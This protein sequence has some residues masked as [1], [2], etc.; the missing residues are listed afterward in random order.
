MS[1]IPGYVE[2]RSSTIMAAAAKACDCLE[3]EK[4]KVDTAHVEWLAKA[5]AFYADKGWWQ[6]FW[7]GI[8]FSDTSL[9]ERGWPRW[10]KKDEALIAAIGPSVTWDTRGTSFDWRRRL[11]HTH[12]D[13]NVLIAVDDWAEILH[14]A[15][16]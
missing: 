9:T 1:S 2:V 14:W 15:G 16:K 3:G 6:R 7:D 8:M 12:A 10:Y 4:R 13:A 11:T 5:K